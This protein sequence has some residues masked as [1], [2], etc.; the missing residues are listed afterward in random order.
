M[1][2][3][4]WIIESLMKNDQRVANIITDIARDEL[5]FIRAKMMKAESIGPILKLVNVSPTAFR[6][7]KSSIELHWG[8]RMFASK[9]DIRILLSNAI[10]PIIGRYD[11]NPQLSINY[12]YKKFIPFS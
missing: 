12:W 5:G 2:I 6:K 11:V 1:K 4:K 8:W 3:T 9:D 10:L 7:L